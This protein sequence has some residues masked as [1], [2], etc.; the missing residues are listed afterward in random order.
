MMK[1]KSAAY[2]LGGMKAPGPDSFTSMFYQNSWDIVGADICCFVKS[3][4]V[5]EVDVACLNETNMVLIPTIDGANSLNHYRPISL[6]NFC[7]KIV[8]RIIMNRMKGL[9]PRFISPNQRAFVPG[10]LI[11]GNLV[12]AHEAFHYL[13]TKKKA[14]IMKWQ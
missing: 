4:F 10:R 13:K 6:C 14:K 8:Y 11:Q 12:V 2:Q 3:F 5:N 7:Y 9:L 1:I